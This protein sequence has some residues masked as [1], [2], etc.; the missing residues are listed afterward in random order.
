MPIV[1]RA[2]PRIRALVIAYGS[3]TIEQTSRPKLANEN[4]TLL[5]SDMSDSSTNG[6]P[7]IRDE[8]SRYYDSLVEEG[9]G[10]Q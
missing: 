3:I 9:Q 10:Q 7:N 1:L 8:I 2:R 4:T 6:D 5:Q